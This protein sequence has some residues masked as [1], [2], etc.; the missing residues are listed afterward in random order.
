[1]KSDYKEKLA[2]EDV[3]TLDEALE[4]AKKVSSDD[5]ADKDALEA[6][7]KEL[8]DKIM[9]IGAKM[10][11]AAEAEKPAD[12]TKTENDDKKS[13]KKDKDGPVEGEVV[14]EK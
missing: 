10:Y 11:E 4:T 8:N 14:D 6:A 2:E 1:M 5:K 3:K 7:A 9:P 12:D 13:D